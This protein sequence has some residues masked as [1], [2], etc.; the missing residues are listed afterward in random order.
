MEILALVFIGIVLAALEVFLP[1]GIL[2][3]IAGAL[4]IIASVLAWSDY[5]IVGSFSV[6]AGS[7]ILIIIT[8]FLECKLLAKTGYADRIFLKQAS[9]GH[10]L[11]NKQEQ[12]LKGKSGYTLTKLTPTGL[13]NLDGK[14]YEAFSR[15]GHMDKDTPVIVHEVDNFRLIVGRKK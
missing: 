15:D 8:I 9:A 14:S 2:G 13:I 12:A 3:F 4:I 11:D 10:V 1:G 5:G 7:M 6:A